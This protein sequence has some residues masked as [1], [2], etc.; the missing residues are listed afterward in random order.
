MTPPNIRP[1]PK[2]LNVD[3]ATTSPN[4]EPEPNI[5][6]EENSP[7]QEGIIKE[8]YVAPDKSYLEQLQELIKLVNTSR[9]VQKYLL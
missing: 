4:L 9:V 1:P 3:N 5:D 8:T 6:F 7:H 2:P